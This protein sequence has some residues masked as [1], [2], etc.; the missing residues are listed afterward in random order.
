MNRDTVTV[1]TL[2][3]AYVAPSIT[4]KPFRPRRFRIRTVASATRSTCGSAR[5]SKL[6]RRAAGAA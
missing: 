3:P 6:N 1:S 4:M 2:P 5:H